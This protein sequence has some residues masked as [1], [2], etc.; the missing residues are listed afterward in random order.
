[1]GRPNPSTYLIFV[2]LIGVVVVVGSI[3]IYRL[4]RDAEEDLTPATTD[5]LLR[6][7]EEALA[8]GEMDQAE[9]DRVTAALRAKGG[10]VA[11]IIAPPVLPAG[12]ARE[13]SEGVQADTG[14][15]A[16]EEG[17]PRGS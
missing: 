8:D 17:A 11:S 10:G 15:A 3:L 13:D 16:A 5:D 14:S 9:F 12:P 7:F 1:M 4:R 6:D 2:A